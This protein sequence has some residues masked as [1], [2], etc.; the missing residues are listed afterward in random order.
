MSDPGPT[1]TYIVPPREP[2]GDVGR[3]GSVVVRRTWW[4]YFQ[5]LGVILGIGQGGG[6]V[7]LSLV[8]L[9]N[10]VFAEMGRSPE[11]PVA[12]D[13][14]P[15]P[16]PPP[17]ALPQ[18]DMDAPRADL[19]PLWREIDQIQKFMV[20]ARPPI[21]MPLPAFTAAGG[22]LPP[23]HAVVDTVALVAGV[24]TVTLARAA[25]FTSAASYVV[26]ANDA[27]GAAVVCS[28]SNI[29]GSSFQIFGSVTDAVT[30]LAIG[31]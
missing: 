10:F 16:A 6:T 31:N 18:P 14:L 28:T 13:D 17:P 5:S 22:A 9:E 27:S 24:A 26:L 1:T 15:P 12:V 3:D 23:V 30:F 29:S 7:P 11:S 25:Q 2:I 20:S 4:R 19:A 21:P 8:D